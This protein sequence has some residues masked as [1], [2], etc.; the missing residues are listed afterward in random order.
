MLARMRLNGCRPTLAWFTTATW[1]WANE[2]AGTIP[3][4]LGGGQWHENFVYSDRY[5]ETGKDVLEYGL[6]E[7][8]Y[9]G[10]YD[11]VV[12]YAMPML[13]QALITS[14]FRIADS[15][16]LTECYGCIGESLRGTPTKFCEH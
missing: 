2:N 1:G 4:F 14:F 16:N 13:I 5:F 15:P 11:H 6:E 8:G 3:F 7:Y 10:S 12:S 9:M